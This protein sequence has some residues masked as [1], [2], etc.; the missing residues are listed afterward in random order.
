MKPE[1]EGDHGPEY[2]AVPTVQLRTNRQEDPVGFGLRLQFDLA[3]PGGELSVVVVAVCETAG[4]DVAA[5][6][7]QLVLES[8]N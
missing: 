1:A 8:G 7:D 4:W 6:T 5:L 2:A 3:F